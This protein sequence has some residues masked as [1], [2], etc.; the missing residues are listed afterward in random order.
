VKV[1][2]HGA[3]LESGEPRENFALGDSGERFQ[4]TLLELCDP[5]AALIEPGPQ[6]GIPF[7]LRP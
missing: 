7:A 6:R 3:M 4:A 1:R 5:G 2:Y